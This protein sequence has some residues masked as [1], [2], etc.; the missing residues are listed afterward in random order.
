MKQA[1]R[2]HLAHSRSKSILT[3]AEANTVGVIEPGQPV[4]MI[5]GKNAPGLIRVPLLFMTPKWMNWTS[6]TTR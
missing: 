5:V 4:R 6:L 1:R 2:W 3:L